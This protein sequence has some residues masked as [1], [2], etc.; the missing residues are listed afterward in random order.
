MAKEN[1]FDLMFSEGGAEGGFLENVPE[2][3]ESAPRIHLIQALSDAAQ[4]GDAKPGQL[5]YNVTG[6]ALNDPG[7]DCPVI[8]LYYWPNRVLFPQRDSG[9]SQ[10]LCGSL[11]GKTGVGL[12]GGECI[13]CP[14]SKW[15][16]GK[17]GRENVPPECIDYHNFGMLLPNESVGERLAICSF[18]KT[19]FRAGRALLNRLRGLKRDPFA[20]VFQLGTKH[21]EKGGNRWW[22]T[23]FRNWTDTNKLEKPLNLFAPGDWE[24]LANEGREAAEFFRDSHR[25]M[26][27][28]QLA[29]PESKTDSDE[30][31]F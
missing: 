23:E 6:N 15:G 25:K 11:D 18:G 2:G 4:D 22:V 27:E 10:I 30:V 9:I 31:P 20:Y 24:E 1:K 29:L 5:I 7:G 12:P 19:S 13:G 28:E 16:A 26:R 21:E 8:P 17:D 14:K 3:K